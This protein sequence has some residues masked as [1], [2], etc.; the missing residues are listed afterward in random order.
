[1]GLLRKKENAKSV[2][3]FW[4]DYEEKLGVKILAYSLAQYLGGHDEYPHPMWGLVIVSENGFIFHHFPHEGWL[5]A[6]TRV[7][8]GGEGPKEKIIIIPKEKLKSARLDAPKGFFK[9]FF[10]YTPPRLY[11][12]Y[13]TEGGETAMLAAETDIRA[14]ETARALDALIAAGL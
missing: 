7:T 12:E 11:V 10:K 13:E 1:M 6:I 2:D 4:K 9:R 5:Q 14:E 3:D 8:T